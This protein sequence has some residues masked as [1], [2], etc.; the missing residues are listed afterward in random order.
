M[1]VKFF[2][3]DWD[4]TVDDDNQNDWNVRNHHNLNLPKEVV[5]EVVDSP[6][7]TDA[8]MDWGAD[9]LSDTYGYCVNGF[10]FEVIKNRK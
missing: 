7:E 10:N 5:L 1:Q 9:V 3:I 2:D 6:N 8:V 4:T